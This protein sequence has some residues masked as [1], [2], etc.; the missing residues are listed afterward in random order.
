MQVRCLAQG[1]R[2]GKSALNGGG[3]PLITPS[4]LSEEPGVLM[5]LPLSPQGKILDPFR[6]TTFYIY[7][8]LV[9]FALILSCF[10]EKPPFFSPK[11]VDTVSFPRRLGGSGGSTPG[12]QPALPSTSSPFH[13]Q[14]ISTRATWAWSWRV[15]GPPP[16]TLPGEGG[17]H[18]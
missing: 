14:V 3:G 15:R 10:R 7:F 2:K 8:A 18:P 6:F 13:A 17:G 4:P 11:N 12:P 5:P 1:Q 16:S 9:L